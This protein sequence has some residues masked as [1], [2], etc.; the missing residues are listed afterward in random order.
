MKT[1]VPPPGQTVVPK[2]DSRPL[3]RGSPDQVGMADQGWGGYRPSYPLLEM[4]GA[5]KRRSPCPSRLTVR[6]HG[7]GAAERVLNAGKAEAVE[8]QQSIDKGRHRAAELKGIRPALAADAW[9]W[10]RPQVLDGEL[11]HKDQQ[12]DAVP[13]LR[14][15]QLPYWSWPTLR[16][17]PA[18]TWL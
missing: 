1:A 3:R 18:E 15:R 5:E 7:R 14:A 12:Y 11:V 10:S 4:A 17:L 2:G 13:K 16:G 9:I 6:E 8:L